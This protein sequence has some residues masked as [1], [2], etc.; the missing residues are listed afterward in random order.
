MLIPSYVNNDL[1]ME[2]FIFA[3]GDIVIDFNSVNSRLIIKNK[4]LVIFDGYIETEEDF[5][6]LTIQLKI[7]I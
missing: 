7:K 1:R 2:Y 3:K 6:K 4:D 5:E